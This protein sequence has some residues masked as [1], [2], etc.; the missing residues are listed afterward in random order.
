MTYMS[1]FPYIQIASDLLQQKYHFDKIRAGY[2]FGVPYIISAVLSPLLGY[3]IDR[4]GRR[5]F[6]M[7]LSSVFLIIAFLSSMMMPECY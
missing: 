3:L 7:C 4:I 5:V 1:I 6:L 2:M